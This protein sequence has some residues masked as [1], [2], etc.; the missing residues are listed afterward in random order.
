VANHLLGMSIASPVFP[1]KG[2]LSGSRSSPKKSKRRIEVNTLTAETLKQMQD[3]NEEFLLINTLDEEHFA[4]THIPGSVNIPLAGE[5]FASRVEQEAG[6]KQKKVVVYCASEQCQ[7]STK[8]A[9]T[10]EAAGFS[11]VLDFEA[12]AE[13]WQQAGQKL[14]VG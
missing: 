2:H 8:A 7:S 1:T 12:G 3:Q 4:A 10:L 13:G 5:D 6:S 9:E 11:N 14:T